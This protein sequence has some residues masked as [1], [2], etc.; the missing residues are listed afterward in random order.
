MDPLLIAGVVCF[1]VLPAVIGISL[2]SVIDRKHRA[3]VEL[4]RSWAG[5]NG[6]DYVAHDDGVV[7]QFAHFP[8]GQGDPRDWRT[9]HVLRSVHRGRQLL[10]FE[11]R[12]VD[13]SHGSQ[14]TWWHTVV[15]VETPTPR[16]DLAV[17]KPTAERR[18]LDRVGIRDLELESEEFN[19]AFGIHTASPRFAYDALPATTMQWMLD[20]PLGRDIEFRFD[21][22]HLVTWQHG[23]VAENALHLA[24]A[25]YL[26]DFMERVPAFVWE[27]DAY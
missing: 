17:L 7:S 8:F 2:G 21:G 10:I 11:Y 15:A 12:Y 1:F 13:R 18:M 24:R 23:L 9:Q 16:P 20:H 5:R 25:D 4:I 3:R 19:Q 27:N 6:W 14:T 22:H 26:I